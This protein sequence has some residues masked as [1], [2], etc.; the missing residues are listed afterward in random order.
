MA[1]ILSCSRK[2]WNRGENLDLAHC[3]PRPW[4]S[5]ALERVQ[6]KSPPEIVRFVG[7]FLE[8]LQDNLDHL[9]VC[10]P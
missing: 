4:D 3:L 1:A 7:E 10:I 9:F 2:S 8:E 5:H 6:A